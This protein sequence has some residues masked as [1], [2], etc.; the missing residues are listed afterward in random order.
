MP[1][2][3]WPCAVAKT[4]ADLIKL[5]DVGRIGLGLAADLILFKGRSFSELLSRPQHDRIVLRYGQRIDTTLPDYSELD[6]LVA[7]ET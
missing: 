4:A 5:P 6:D 1:Y 3:D 2:G 7:R